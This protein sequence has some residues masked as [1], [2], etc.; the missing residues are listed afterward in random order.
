MFL[1]RVLVLVFVQSLVEG[2]ST[3]LFCT[4]DIFNDWSVNKVQSIFTIKDKVYIRSGANFSKLWVY[5]IN[6]QQ[7]MEN[8]INASDIFPGFP[9]VEFVAA[10]LCDKCPNNVSNVVI[11]V[12]RETL[13]EYHKFGTFRL[14]SDGSLTKIDITKDEDKEL[15]KNWRL[16][17]GEE[18]FTLDAPFYG[19]FPETMVTLQ[20]NYSNIHGFAFFPSLQIFHLK[21]YTEIGRYFAYRKLRPD[22]SLTNWTETGIIGEAHVLNSAFYIKDKIYA[23][24][25]D[26]QYFARI[27]HEII[28]DTDQSGELVFKVTSVVSL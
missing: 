16:R 2:N 12:G 28:V 8:Y 11:V 24:D 13:K 7:M 27:S 14:Q 10:V 26:M 21:Y 18:P 9:I 25:N 20:T 1:I 6:S 17:D 23:L 4:H 19:F 15:L 5:D 3:S 22:G